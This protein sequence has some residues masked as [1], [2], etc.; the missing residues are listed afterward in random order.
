MPA[1]PSPTIHNVGS[2]PLSTSGSKKP[3]NHKI[4]FENQGRSPL[5][6][7]SPSKLNT[8]TSKQLKTKH[9]SLLATKPE[10]TSLDLISRR[11]NKAGVN[12]LKIPPHPNILHVDISTST[13]KRKQNEVF[14][15][16]EHVGGTNQMTI[17]TPSSPV[18][19]SLL[20][21]FFRSS[22]TKRPRQTSS[23]LWKLPTIGEVITEFSDP[24]TLLLGP[25]TAVYAVKQDPGSEKASR[26]QSTVTYDSEQPPTLAEK[27]GENLLDGYR[28]NC[29]GNQAPFSSI[30]FESILSRWNSK[31]LGT[32]PK[33]LLKIMPL[34]LF[35]HLGANSR[36][37]PAWTLK[38]QRCK[39]FR[40][41]KPIP[42]QLQPLIALERGEL[43]PAIQQLI[44]VAFC[45]SHRKVAFKEMQTW[46]EEFRELSKIK[47]YDSVF[48]SANHRLWA[49]VCWIRLLDRATLS[50]LTPSASLQPDLDKTVQNNSHPVNPIQVF[51]PYASEVLSRAISDELAKLL[52]KPLQKSDIKYQG[53]IYIFWQR[54]NFGHLK[55]GRSG[56]VSRRL[57]EWNKQCKKD[58]EV[59]FPTKNGDESTPD[60]QQV[61][62]ISRVE[63]LVH[64][65]LMHQRKVEKRCPGCFKSHVEWFETPKD[66]AI[67]VVRKWSAWMVT[68]PYE[69]QMIDDEEQWILK[70]EERKKLDK[71]CRP[72]IDFPTASLPVVKKEGLSSSTLTLAS[73]CEMRGE[74]VAA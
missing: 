30:E 39:V 74:D 24:A 38:G 49:L 51:K 6:E 12:A 32:A 61:P 62:H 4:V 29:S 66:I 28:I 42:T 58:M 68:R 31:D 5:Q 36:K 7:A 45:H 18:D 41:L 26:A 72:G 33:S 43:L 54:G 71:L 50:Q 64:L 14:Y 9:T 35:E 44:G 37:C 20:S 19:I 27:T 17:R 15:H 57:S 22:K 67:G 48:E 34:E 63:A 70:S 60:V 55:I 40:A 11:R 13:I 73:V 65:E 52:T 59:H 3:N 53:S 1:P 47:D 56:N 2:R 69:K 21:V 16:G 10:D 23:A 46:S 8:I 25:E